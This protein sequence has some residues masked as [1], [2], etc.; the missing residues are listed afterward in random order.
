MKSA[1]APSPLQGAGEYGFRLALV[2]LRP[3]YTPDGRRE[4]AA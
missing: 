1:A 2:G 3:W 4:R